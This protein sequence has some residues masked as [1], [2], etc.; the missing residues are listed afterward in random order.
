MTSDQGTVSF[1]TRGD[2]RLGSAGDVFA[3]G[4]HEN[5]RIVRGT[6][7]GCGTGTIQYGSGFTLEPGC[8]PQT[9]RTI[10]FNT[11]F[12]SPPSVT[13]TAIGCAGRSPPPR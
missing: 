6:I 7:N 3:A 2:I 1:G 5:L 11:P 10:F 12:S 9:T 13:A 4:G 8:A